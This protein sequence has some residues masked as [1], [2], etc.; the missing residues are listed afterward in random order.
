MTLEIAHSVLV[1]ERDS[2]ILSHS[3]IGFPFG[4]A[5]E[6]A[7]SKEEIPYTV[8][9]FRRMPAGRF[10][11]SSATSDPVPSARSGALPRFTHRN[12][13][14]FLIAN[15]QRTYLQQQVTRIA[16][17]TLVIRRRSRFHETGHR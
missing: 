16:F 5:G 1:N 15:H 6:Y 8:V 4:T 3:V 2:E 12:P 11:P 7:L 17:E 14:R 9:H 10:Q 13:F